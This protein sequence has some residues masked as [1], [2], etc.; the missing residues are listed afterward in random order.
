MEGINQGKKIERK[1]KNIE[2]VRKLMETNS[3]EK[4]GDGRFEMGEVLCS[5]IAQPTSPL[6]ILP[7]PFFSSSLELIISL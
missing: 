6:S 1:E 5:M 4:K 2:Y 7:S 3:K